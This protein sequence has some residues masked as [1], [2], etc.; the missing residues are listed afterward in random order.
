[1]FI[2]IAEA[3]QAICYEVWTHDPSRIAEI[4]LTTRLL[5]KISKNAIVRGY[6]QWTDAIEAL[7]DGD[8]Q[9]CLASINQSEATFL[10]EGETL[11]A[12]KTQTSKLYA[13]ALLGRYDEAVE[14]GKK[15]LEVFVAN[16]DLYS[17][18]KIEHNIGNLFWRRDM[19]RESEPYLASAHERFTL[20]DDQR[21]LAMVENCQAFVKTLQNDFRSA[22]PIYNRSLDRAIENGLT[23]T[24]AEIEI[25]LSNLYLFKGEYDLALKFLEGSR[26]K[27]DSL[28]MPAQ[29]A[30]CELEI[31]EIYSELSLLPEALAYYD[32]AGSAFTN[33]GGQAEL[34]RSLL[35][36][37]RILQRQGRAADS[38][39]KLDLAGELFE[40]EGNAVAAATVRL[41]RARSLLEIGDLD[42]AENEAT[43]ALAA[44]KE[45][46]NQRLE[47]VARW[48][49]CE[50]LFADGRG[51]AALAELT[52]VLNRSCDISHE[53]QYLC[54]VLLGRITGD[55]GRFVDAIELA[56]RSRSRLTSSDLRTSFFAEKLTPYNELIAMSIDDKKYVEALQW[57]ER[58]RARSMADQ[59][60]SSQ[61]GFDDDSKLRSIR[62]DINWFHRRLTSL[63]LATESDRQTA[64]ELR[65]ATESLERQYAE[66]LRRGNFADGQPHSQEFQFD[67]RSLQDKLDDATVIEF[68]SINGKISAFVISGS[69]LDAVTDYLDEAEIAEEIT[70]YL[71]QLK[72]GRFIGRLSEEKRTAAFERLKIRSRSLYDLVFLPLE[73]LLK[74]DHLVILPSGRLHELPFQALMDGDTFVCERSRISFAPSLTILDGLLAKAQGD[75]RAALIA[76]LADRSMPNAEIE[77]DN[78]A[79]FFDDP[80]V[81]KGEKLTYENLRKS[82]A[83]KGILHL[84]C[85]G[86]FR[87]D[88][89]S[90]SALEL[91]AEKITANQIHDFP[92]ERCIVV[93]SSC[94]GA[95]NEVVRGEELVGFTGAFF[96][97]GAATLI[98]SLWRVNDE[99]ALELMAEFYSGFTNGLD[100]AAALQKAQ[101]HLIKRRDHPYFWA[102]FIVS[103]RP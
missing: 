44:F 59:I 48:I 27:Y 74:T 100:A 83:G 72:T 54:S 43:S 65:A 22:E 86:S 35:G 58:S 42:R 93:L 57:H 26:K 36:E 29:S 37:A 95:L 60:A 71:F 17:A 38:N 3:L 21:Q 96:A 19:Y 28:G 103:G 92:L 23:V 16:H 4:A 91:F 50:I 94:E 12:A 78:I 76:G 70:Q 25:G 85:H 56:E 6:Y 102:P 40:K 62:D 84:A 46:S 34:A 55:R 10:G 47:L 79:G 97:A 80:V 88:N 9:N 61:R 45:S 13:L 8:L 7:V 77:A 67:L 81:L 15:A 33:L 89:P 39:A 82:V 69:D 66:L 1:M 51:E 101:I 73:S 68:I 30:N 90:F 87:P 99:T 49:N 14:C 64:V 32:S 41:A 24:A 75:N 2:P 31:A 20:I 98:H 53:I 5:S 11:L 63:D 18:G 52:D